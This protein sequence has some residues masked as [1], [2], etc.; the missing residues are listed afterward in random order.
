MTNVLAQSLTDACGVEPGF[1]CEWVFDTTDSE[2]V[3][4]IV[5]WLVERPLKI[6]VVL[7]G[8]WVVNRF[9]TRAVDRLVNRLVESRVKEE[10]EAESDDL[11][12][13]MGRRARGKLQRIHEHKSIVLRQG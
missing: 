3:A 9:V 4:E 6:V 12:A 11:V 2:A 8:A 1:I 7:L 13:R 5:G 10:Q